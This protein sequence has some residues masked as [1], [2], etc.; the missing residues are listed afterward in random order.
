M[1]IIIFKCLYIY[2]FVLIYRF[3]FLLIILYVYVK[4]MNFIFYSN[5]I[6]EKFELDFKYILNIVKKFYFIENKIFFLIIDL[7]VCK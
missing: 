2:F 5:R 3:F 7:Y 6:F 4:C 1:F